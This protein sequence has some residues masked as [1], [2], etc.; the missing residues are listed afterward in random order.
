MPLT[1]DLGDDLSGK[2]NPGLMADLLLR[3]VD[4]KIV[5]QT[6]VEVQVTLGGKRLSPIQNRNLTWSVA[7]ELSEMTLKPGYDPNIEESL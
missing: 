5:R 4:S 1:I 3:V 7:K 6:G 2:V